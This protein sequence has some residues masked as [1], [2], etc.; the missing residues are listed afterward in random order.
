MDT[1]LYRFTGEGLRRR[2]KLPV[3]H[4]LYHRDGTFYECLTRFPGA[5]CDPQGWVHFD[6]E[7]EFERDPRIHIGRKVNVPHGIFR[8]PNNATVTIVWKTHVCLLSPSHPWRP[9]MVVQPALPEG[10]QL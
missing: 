10:G 2:Y 6:S 5:L 9:T 3:R 4:A 1:P 7:E 8:H